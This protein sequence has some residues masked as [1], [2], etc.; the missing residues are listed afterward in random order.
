MVLNF[1]EMEAGDLDLPH[2]EKMAHELSGM[3]EVTPWT[4]LLCDEQHKR[5]TL[6]PMFDSLTRPQPSRRGPQVH[7]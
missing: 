6:H 5:Q 4:A 3:G 7:P 1:T 2:V